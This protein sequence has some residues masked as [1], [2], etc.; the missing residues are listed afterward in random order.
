MCKPTYNIQVHT[1]GW[2]TSS[3][4]AFKRLTS[5]AFKLFAFCCKH[6]F[7]PVMGFVFNITTKLSI[8]CVCVFAKSHQLKPRFL[9]R[10]GCLIRSINTVDRTV[11]AEVLR[12]AFAIATHELV[13]RTCGRLRMTVCFIRFVQTI[14]EAVASETCLETVQVVTT[15]L[16]AWWTGWH[17]YGHCTSQTCQWK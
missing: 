6:R 8:I 7:Q 12:N 10:P 1:C 17:T 2:Y 3:I 11:T 14:N 9:T 16:W 15:W 5:A 13:L 4:T